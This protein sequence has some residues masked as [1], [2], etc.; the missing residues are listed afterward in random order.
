MNEKENNNNINSNK[1]NRI[2]IIIPLILS[3]EEKK[4]QWIEKLYKISFANNCLKFE[5]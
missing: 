4:M 5:L 2:K 3:E 1:E